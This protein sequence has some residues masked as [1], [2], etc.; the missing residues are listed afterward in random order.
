M[1]KIMEAAKL[2]IVFPILTG[3]CFLLFLIVKTLD[4][5]V[6]YTERSI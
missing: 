2:L 3:V 6:Y 1:K 5:I 4:K